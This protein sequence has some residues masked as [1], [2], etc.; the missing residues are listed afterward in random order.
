MRCQKM[1]AHEQGCL[2]CEYDCPGSRGGLSVNFYPK[3]TACTP[4]NVVLAHNAWD[5]SLNMEDYKCTTIASA[6]HFDKVIILANC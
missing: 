6:D 2:Q 1:L 3:R 5:L 4:Q